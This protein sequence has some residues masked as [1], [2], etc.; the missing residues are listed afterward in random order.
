VLTKVIGRDFGLEIAGVKVQDLSSDD[1]GEVLDL[2]SRYPVLVI[3]GQELSPDEYEAF[4]RHFGELQDHTRR[5]FTLPGHPT[6]YVLSNKVVDGKPIGVHRDGMGWHTDGTYVAKP[7]ESTVLHALEV[8]PKGGDT[9]FADTRSAFADLDEELKGSIRGRNV[10]HSFEYLVSRLNDVAKSDVTDEQRAA[11]PEVEHPLVITRD[12]GA[13]YLYLTLGSARVIVGMDEAD[14][15]ALLRR[16]VDHVT[17]EQ[18]VY[19]HR[20]QQGDV[21]VWNNLRSMH[22][23]TGYDDER[24]IRHVHRLWIKSPVDL[25]AS[26][27][28]AA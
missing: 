2:Y 14:S 16:L 6:I 13:E 25:D 1:I 8:P 4:G 18:Y 9:L 21:V 12:D 28:R 27:G 24:Y 23:A 17:Q 15:Q 26:A 11:T 22:C 20:W 3:R 10:L 7:L 19:R 5:Q